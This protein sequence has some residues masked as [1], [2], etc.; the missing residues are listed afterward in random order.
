MDFKMLENNEDALIHLR[1]ELF[2]K[3][4][5]LH[6][7]ILYI[8]DESS[9]EDIDTK[10]QIT[11]EALAKTKELKKLAEK[12]VLMFEKDFSIEQLSILKGREV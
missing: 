3:L 6:D 12:V 7:S 4:S 1:H 11:D 5:L 9:S 10:K 8:S 2:G